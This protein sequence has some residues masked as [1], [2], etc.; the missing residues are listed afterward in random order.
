VSLRLRLCVTSHASPFIAE[1]GH[2]QRYWAPTCG[3]RDIKNITLGATSVCC[4]GNILV[5]WCPRSA[6]P[7]RAGEASC[8]RDDEHSAPLG[9]G[10]LFA[11]RL[12]R[13]AVCRTTLT[14]SASGLDKAHY[15]LRGHVSH[16]R[17]GRWHVLSA[18]NAEATRLY[19]PCARLDPLAYVAGHKP[20]GSSGSPPGREV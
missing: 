16:Q 17:G 1:G 6:Y 11:N 8:R 10:A 2:A 13:R 12:D 20:R 9:T 15:L 18:I 5:S 3:H 4:W 14:S 7:R 19:G